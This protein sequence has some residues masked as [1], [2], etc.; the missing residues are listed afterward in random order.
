MNLKLRVK[1]IIKKQ[2]NKFPRLFNSLFYLKSLLLNYNDREHRVSYGSQNPQNHFYVIRPRTNGIEGLMALF[3][4]ILKLS[5]YAKKQGYVPVVDLKNYQTQY[6]DGEHNVWEWFFLQKNTFSL[7]EVYR[8]KNVVLS[9]YRRTNVYNEDIVSR[10]V[11]SDLEWNRYCHELFFSLFA[12]NAE[13][14]QLVAQE[15][16]GIPIDN[17]VGVFLRGTDYI[18]LKPTGEAI[19]PS[20]ESVLKKTMEMCQK[21][22]IENVFL[23]TE[24]ND[25][26]TYFRNRLK[27]ALHIVSFDSFIENYKG[28]TYLSK[29]NVLDENKYRLGLHYLVKIIL[30]SKCR[31]FVGS[32]ASGSKVA[33]IL[34]GNQYTDYHV[35]DLGDY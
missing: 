1:Q 16:K 33:W 19:Q 32:I 4:W 31:Y 27:D 35:F 13:V 17:C 26:Y 18:K 22:G 14:E 34:N 7:E 24:D 21:H 23:V 30:L 2:L 15:K 28:N 20:M 25:I 6:S 11:F 5:D 3:I 8:S 9:G 10:R 29:A 12:V